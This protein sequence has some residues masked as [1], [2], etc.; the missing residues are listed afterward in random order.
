MATTVAKAVRDA[1]ALAHAAR[2]EHEACTASGC[3][4]PGGMRQ[5][6]ALARAPAQDGRLLLM[7][8]PFAALD[9][10]TRDVLHD[11]PARVWP[12]RDCPCCSSP[13]TCGRR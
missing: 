6:V 4:L 8:E 5:R 11:E 9:A 1:T 3:G 12:R 10:V 13:T 2:I 7:D